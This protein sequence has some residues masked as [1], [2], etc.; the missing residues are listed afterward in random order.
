MVEASITVWKVLAQELSPK[1]AEG[2]L[3][4][5]NRTTLDCA[6]VL[7]QSERDLSFCLRSLFRVR[8]SV[9]DS[10]GARILNGTKCIKVRCK[11]GLSG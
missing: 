8:F 3:R 2:P 11:V 5:N 4:G 6:S 1:V 7:A 10:Q 9:K